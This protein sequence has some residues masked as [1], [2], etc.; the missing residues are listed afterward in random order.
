[1][2]NPREVPA[3]MQ[4]GAS[5]HRV[6]KTFFDSVQQDRALSGEALIDLF[7]DDFAQ[8]VIDDPYQRELY[9]QQAIQQLGDFLKIVNRSSP[10]QGAAH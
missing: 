1:M 8:A 4:Y 2:E 6:L 10:L 5:M 3:A 7:R 9:E